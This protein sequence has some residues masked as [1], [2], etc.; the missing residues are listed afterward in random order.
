MAHQLLSSNLFRTWGWCTINFYE[1]RKKGT[2]ICHFVHESFYP[3]L[4]SVHATDLVS[5][6]NARHIYHFFLNDIF[7]QIKTH[8]C[9]WSAYK[10]FWYD[11]YMTWDE[12]WCMSN[13]QRGKLFVHIRALAFHCKFNIS[14]RRNSF[15]IVKIG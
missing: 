1:R 14:N 12:K 8:G 3:A 7:W 9:I 5:W 2:K 11:T 6:Q 13:W 4:K 10:Y 15:T